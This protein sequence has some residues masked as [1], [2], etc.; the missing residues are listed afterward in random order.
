MNWRK[1]VKIFAAAVSAVI[2]FLFAAYYSIIQWAPI[3]LKYE[4]MNGYA[5]Y[6]S[7]LEVEA[8]GGYTLGITHQRGVSPKHYEGSITNGELT[9]LKRKLLSHYFWQLPSDLSD[10][11]GEDLSNEKLYV[12]VAGVTNETKG[13][14]IRNHRFRKMVSEL[15]QWHSMSYTASSTRNGKQ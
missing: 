3:H 7:I 12:T 6:H 10:H 2:L 9:A 1:A 11:W 5:G 4:V 13:Y 15:E 8:D 14:G